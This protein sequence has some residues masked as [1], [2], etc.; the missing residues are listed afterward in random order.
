MKTHS[1]ARMQK[2]LT[3]F[4][5]VFDW[6]VADQRIPENPI[7][8]ARSLSTGSLL[9]RQK[10]SRKKML[11]NHQQVFALAAETGSHYQLMILVMA[12][13]GLR[14][15]EVVALQSGDID[16][17][18]M[19]IHV[20]RAFSDVGG[21]LVE[22]PPKSGKARE[23]PI[24][25]FLHSSIATRLSDLVGDHAL[26]FTTTSGSTIRYSRWLKDVFRPAASRAGLI[27]LTPHAL[28]HTFAALAIQ[29][30]ANPKVLQVAM[31]HSDIRLTLDTYGGLY[32]DDLDLLAERLDTASKALKAAPAALVG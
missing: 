18:T 25:S 5:Q 8:R 20:V 1:V 2:T 23:V 4:S 10:S 7:K 29:A 21:V 22:V 11:L 30:G 16:L 13:T 32:G 28:R 12:Y 31:G 3:I 14:F 15:G 24:P 26:V 27:G 19:R 6:A 17:S 9:G